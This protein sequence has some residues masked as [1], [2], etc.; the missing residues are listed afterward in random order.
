MGLTRKK[1]QEL[2][3]SAPIPINVLEEATPDDD[4][5]WIHYLHTR[6]PRYRK[7]GITI[8]E[9]YEQWLAA[10]IKSRGAESTGK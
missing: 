10:R 3:A 2:P 7:P 4:T 1:K 9:E 6:N 8:K 5:A